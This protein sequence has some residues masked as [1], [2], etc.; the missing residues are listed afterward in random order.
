MYCVSATQH[1]HP[2]VSH[3]AA[4]KLAAISKRLQN[5]CLPNTQVY[6][7]LLLVRLV[8]FC[9]VSAD[10]HVLLFTANARISVQS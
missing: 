7:W 1:A 2:C 4:A 8:R 5:A 9:C 3:N 10:A 6:E